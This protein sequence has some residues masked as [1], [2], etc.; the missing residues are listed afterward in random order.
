MYS[1][2]TLGKDLL[3]NLNI[4]ILKDHINANCRLRS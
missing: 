1:K 4:E 3:I 2:F